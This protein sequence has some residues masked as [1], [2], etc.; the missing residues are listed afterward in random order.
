MLF[1]HPGQLQVNEPEIDISVQAKPDTKPGGHPDKSTG[2]LP[3]VAKGAM[4]NLVGVFARTLIASAYTLML[5][6]LLSVTELGQYFLILTIVN[7]LGLVSTIGLDLGV[8]RF[9]SLYAGESRSWLVQKT[10]ATSILICVVISM[11]IT[12]LLI[13][14][15]PFVSRFFLDDDTTATIAIRIFA[16]SIPFW[17]LARLFNATTQ[18]LH[19]MRY[20]VYSRDLSEQIIKFGLSFAVLS[21]GLGLVGVAWASVISI[22]AA[23]VLAAGFAFIIMPAANKQSQPK[24]ERSTKRLLRYSMPLAFSNVLGMVLTWIDLLLLGYLGTPSDVGLYGAALRVGVI[25]SAILLAFATV[26]APVIA[27]LFNRKQTYDLQALFKTLNRWIFIFSLPFII[28]QILFADSIMSLFGGEYSF[29]KEVLIILATGQLLYASA[30]L[31]GNMLLMSGR[32]KL[33]L[34]NILVTLGVNV[35]LCYLLIPTY[36]IN[37][38]GLANILSAGLIISMRSIE[39]WIIM[40]MHAYDHNYIKPV[41]AGAASAALMALATHFVFTGNALSQLVILITGL[42]ATY[43]FATVMM[44]LNDQD[45]N[46]LK[47]IKSRLLPVGTD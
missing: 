4:I 13:M 24:H 42:M 10:V 44:G 8:V 2:Y 25:S 23:A 37:G 20:Q 14:L 12:L 36:G 40:K 43:I 45:R 30:G 41:L 28:A 31:S 39:V 11:F 7:I 47:L 35:G 17:V 5:A 9:V 46:I 33:E 16:L 21:I 6:R 26:F 22:A 1:Y 3:Q 32:S 27:D 19:R 38:A 34:I 18:G 29:G 15:A